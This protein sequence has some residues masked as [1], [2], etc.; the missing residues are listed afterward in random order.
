MTVFGTTS[1]SQTTIAVDVVDVVGEGTSSKSAPDPVAA[2]LIVDSGAR[3]G[4]TTGQGSGRRA[5]K[6][7]DFLR[8]LAS[9]NDA[10]DH[11]HTTESA[12]LQ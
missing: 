3:G 12:P 2:S 10:A 6:W 4:G 1:A 8:F 7:A 11:W 9:T 5:F